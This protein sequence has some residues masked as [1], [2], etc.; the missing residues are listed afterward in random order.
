VLK[1]NSDTQFEE[2]TSLYVGMPD[3]SI[4]KNL[5]Q[6]QS[7]GLKDPC[8]LALLPCDFLNDYP[9]TMFLDADADLVD[10]RADFAFYHVIGYRAAPHAIDVHE[11]A[12]LVRP[13][14]F[15]YTGARIIQEESPANLHL[16]IDAMKARHGNQRWG[17]G[18]L[19]GVSGGGVFPLRLLAQN[20]PRVQL[21]GIF[22]EQEIKQG[23]H[24][25]F[26]RLGVDS[27]LVDL[28]KGET[29]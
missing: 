19:E 15:L 11:G 6:R 26:H 4:N 13:K 3:G 23:R 21:A 9:E 27:V 16:Q 7:S 22:I 12:K 5:L 17:T 24:S 28:G 1:H 2:G 14:P 18:S 20:S 10:D 25:G 29:A 8:D